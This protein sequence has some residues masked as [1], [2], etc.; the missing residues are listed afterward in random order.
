[1]N[2]DARLQAGAETT[3]KLRL[4]HSVTREMMTAESHESLFRIAT[5]AASELL[6]FEYNTIREHDPDG[7]R[8]VPVAV[9]PEL[10]EESDTRRVYDR[11]ETVQ[12]ESVETGEMQVFQEVSAID[13]DAPRDG[14]GSM[15]VV[16]LG[17]YGVLSLGSSEPRSITES[18]EEL[19]RVFGANIET[20]IERIEYVQRLQRQT[21]ELEAKND[22]L[23]AFAGKLSHELRNPITL[24]RGRLELVRETGDFSHLDDLED[25][26]DRM[27]RLVSDILTLSRTGEVSV[28]PEPV[29][30]DRVATESWAAIPTEDT[31][32]EVETSATVLADGDRLR[33]LFENLFRNSVEHGSTSSRPEADDSVEHAGDGVT[34]TVGDLPEGFYVEDTGRG[35]PPSCWESVVDRDGPLDAKWPGFGLPI[36][37]EIAGLHG[38]A[39]DLSESAAG[40]ARFEFRGVDRPSSGTSSR[41]EK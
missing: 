34:V 36:V 41:E 18:D 10:R 39:V 8:L 16:P 32:V 33:Q 7:D 5:A 25:A 12:W 30:L 14:G 1:M 35:L 3:A 40:G 17:D 37:A 9:S 27:D 2:G 29:A 15:V 28:D 11:G 13:D 22:R 23:D 24:L 4:L 38:W 21:A 26:V 20:A 6:G 19:A 31:T